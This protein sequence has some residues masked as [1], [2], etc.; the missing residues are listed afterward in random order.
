MRTSPSAFRPGI[1]SSRRSTSL[2]TTSCRGAGAIAS[3][4]QDFETPDVEAPQNATAVTF[5]RKAAGIKT[6]SPS[7]ISVS[8]L[9]GNGV[10]GS[11]SGT[12]PT[13]SDSAVTGSSSRRT[14]PIAMPRIT[15]T[16]TRW[17]TTTNGSPVLASLRKKVADLF[18]D[19]ELKRLPAPLRA[20]RR[21]RSSTVV[22]GSTFHGTL[23]PAPADKT[24]RRSL[25]M[26]ARILRRRSRC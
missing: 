1:S 25:R 6:L 24:P 15:T 21:V 18:G 5:G 9:N 10:T 14:P 26:S 8:V 22:V 12:R 11:A 4:V 16:S 2:V 19:A 17:C 3:A 20:R 13:S 23:A 7:H